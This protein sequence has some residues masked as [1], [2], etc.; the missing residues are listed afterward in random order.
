[1]ES[2]EVE[3]QRQPRVEW[4]T[5]QLVVYW[6]LV[7]KMGNQVYLEVIEIGVLPLQQEK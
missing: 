6:E 4:V 7:G 5:Q 2:L 1:V 3:F